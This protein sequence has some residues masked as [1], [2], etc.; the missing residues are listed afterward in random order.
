VKSPGATHLT[1]IEGALDMLV[2]FYNQ[3]AGAEN[4]INLNSGRKLL[5]TSF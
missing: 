4:L 3:R 1:N 2:W 5:T